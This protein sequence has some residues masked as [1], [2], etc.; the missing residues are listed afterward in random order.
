ME[1]REIILKRVFDAPIAQVWDAWTTPKGFAAWY[2]KPWEVPKD[3]VSMD[4]RVGGKWKSTT[5]AEGNEI[6]FVGEY[7]EVV[8][9]KKLVFTIEL[10]D[11]DSGGLFELGTV[12]FTDLGDK[13]EMVFTQSGNLPP[14]EYQTGLKD[15]WT[16]FFD[17]LQKYVMGEKKNE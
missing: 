17:H 9:H 16:G 3:S 12:K 2:G 5:I 1:K 14:Q 6:K 15:G 10:A 8:I 7:K 4:V 13:T 11:E